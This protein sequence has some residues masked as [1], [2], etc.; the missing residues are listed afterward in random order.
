MKEWN[1]LIWIPQFAISVVFPLILFLMLAVWLRDSW[2]WGGWVR[3]KEE[4]SRH[5]TDWLRRIDFEKGAKAVLV[6][7]PAPNA[8]EFRKLAQDW[9]RSAAKNGVVA[10]E[11]SLAKHEALAARKA[12]AAK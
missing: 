8:E 5:W 6:S 2:G 10:A 11:E 7:R 9:Y 3:T 1:L 4:R 12:E